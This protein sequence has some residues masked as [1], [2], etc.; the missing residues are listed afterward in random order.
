MTN[1]VTTPS[2]IGCTGST[3]TDDANASTGLLNYGWLTRWIPLISDVVIMANY[4]ASAI[5]AIAGISTAQATS[6]TSMTPGSGAQ[7]CTVQTGKAF[8]KGMWILVARTAAPTTEWMIGQVTS[9]TTGTGALDFTVPAAQYQ[10]SS[11]RT[12]W[13]ISITARPA[14]PFSKGKQMFYG[15]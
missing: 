6:T 14:T 10:G 4:V 5:A 11:A 2:S 15:G 13:T 12:D 7:S 9:Y 8:V 3:Y 1:T